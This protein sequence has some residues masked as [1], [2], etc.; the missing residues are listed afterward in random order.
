MQFETVCAE[1]LRVAHPDRCDHSSYLTNCLWPAR[2]IHNHRRAALL[3]PMEGAASGDKG[4]P[5]AA[6][7]VTAPRERKALLLSQHSI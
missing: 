7:P 2:A 1:T 5:M 6:A 3:A 4:P